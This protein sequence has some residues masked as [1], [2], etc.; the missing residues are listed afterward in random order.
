MATAL[1]M[2]GL[3]VAFAAFMIILMQVEYD[4]GFDR[5]HPHA[6]RIYRVEQQGA[7]GGDE[8][9]GIVSRPLLESLTT[10]SPHVVGGTFTSYLPEQMFFSVASSN[11]KDYYK[12]MSLKVSTGYP[13]V[14][15]FDMLE[16][17]SRALNDPEK[18]LI[19]ESL[20]R[21]LF[22]GEPA[23]GRLLEEKD[24]TYTIG[25]VY[26][27][28]PRNTS[29]RNVVY[30]PIPQDENLNEWRNVSYIAYACIDDPANVAGLA[31]NFK[32]TLDADR[33]KSLER[34]NFRFTPLADTHFTTDVLYESS[35][36]ASRQTLFI[37]SGIALIIILIAGINYT[38]FSAALTPKRIRSINTQKVLG[39]DE[40]T[41]RFALVLEA[42]AIAFVSYLIALFFVSAAQDTFVAPL[43]D[44]D[45]SLAAHPGLVALTGCVAIVTG[46]LA[47]IYPARY[48]TS[49]PPA[50]VLKGNFGLSPKGRQLRNVLISVQF[51][52]SFALIIGASFMYL[53]NHF[54]RHTPLGYG[55][56]QLIITDL[57]DAIRKEGQAFK[58]QLKGFAGIDGIGFSQFLLSANEPF[59]RWGRDYHD[60]KIQFLCLPVDHSFLDVIGIEATEGRGFREQD[61]N[62]GAYIFNERARETYNLALND[63]LRDSVEIVGFIPDI[64]FASLH[65]TVEPMAFYLWTGPWSEPNW[66]AGSLEYAY[67]KVKAGSDM[68]AAIAHVRNTLKE[69]DGEYPFNVRFFDEILNETYEKEQKLGTMISL[70]SFV[71]ILI[72]IVGVFGLVVFDSEY[73]RKEISLRK[74]FGS[75]TSGILLLFNKVYLRI[76]VLCFVLAAPLAWYA[77]SRWLENFAYRTP[78]HWWVYPAAFVVVALFTISV[79]TFQNWRAANAN[80]VENIK[81]E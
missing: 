29:T 3:S 55:K 28:F 73:R 45:L 48:M 63:Q 20:A 51:I 67:V 12:E 21:K 80:P 75:T 81:A 59:M 66:W 33:A 8:W 74:I 15:P 72:S 76:L 53:Q 19:P 62:R 1:N 38:N 34:F 70:F 52:A 10:S 50:L 16:G 17:D 30:L 6:D 9:I 69:F 68:R 78:L 77:V 44:A 32:R 24:K 71:A 40:Q 41:I 65:Q 58:N 57:N 60:E 7:L 37:L 36:K 2:L 13:D 23:T 43:V 18:A 79:V 35:P 42:V 31:E 54:M 11:R 25:G 61:A 22:A 64:K 4:R 46:L 27:D 49:F 39:G 14:F 56:D 26:R 47:G 5:S